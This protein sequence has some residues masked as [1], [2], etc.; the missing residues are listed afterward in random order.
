ML[1]SPRPIRDGSYKFRDQRLCLV[2]EHRN[3]VDVSKD[4]GSSRVSRCRRQF[5]C[6]DQGTIAFIQRRDLKTG[7]LLKQCLRF[8]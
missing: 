8:R 7:Q 2:K 4:F 3:D 1:W 6:L 5:S